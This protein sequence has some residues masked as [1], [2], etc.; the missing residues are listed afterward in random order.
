MTRQ[1]FIPCLML[2]LSL[3]CSRRVS[4]KTVPA[5]VAYTDG[6][7][8]IVFELRNGEPTH[9]RSIPLRAAEQAIAGGSQAFIPGDPAVVERQLPKSSTGDSKAIVTVQRLNGYKENVR[10]EFHDGNRTFIYEYCVDGSHLRAVTS[11][12]HDISGSKISSYAPE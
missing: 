8:V 12:Y 2:I 5:S 9:V 11:E 10:V 3:S 4:P 1:A 7:E 6:F